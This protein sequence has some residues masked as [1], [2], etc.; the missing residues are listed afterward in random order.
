MALDADANAF[1]APL[2]GVAVSHDPPETVAAVA[3]KLSVPPPAFD[4]ERF[5]ERAAAPCTNENVKEAG[6]TLRLGAPG[7]VVV[8]VTATECEVGC[9]SGVVI[10]IVPVCDPAESL[11][12]STVT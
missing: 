9:V 4:T 1:S 11:D 2:A 7:V 3:E 6:S 12:G 8:S 5:C 10:V